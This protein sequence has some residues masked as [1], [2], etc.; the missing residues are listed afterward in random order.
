MSSFSPYLISWNTTKRCNLRCRHCYLDSDALTKKD[1]NELS[2]EEGKRL[3]D[4]IAIVNPATMLILTGGEPLVRED[5]F[6][7]SA[8]ASKKG[9]MVVFGTNATTL[10][11]KTAKEMIKAGV[12]GVGISVD[13]ASP[14][15]HDVFRGMEGAWDK[16]MDGI[17]SCK[18]HGIEFQ[19]Q[20]TVTTANYHEIRDII[21]LS[22][23]LGARVFNLF[24][25][26]CTGRGQDITDISAEQYEEALRLL[27]DIQGKYKN[28][29]VTARCAPHFKR[30]A[31]EKDPES[32][33]TKAAG[34]TGGGCLAAFH[35]CRITPEGDVTPCP[36]I[37]TSVGNVKKENF[38]D[39]WNK[40]D[41]FQNMRRPKLTGRCGDCEYEYICGGCRARAYAAKND[42]MAEDP[43]CKYEPGKIGYKIKPIIPPHPPLAKGGRGDLDTEEIGWSTEAE[44][45]LNKVPYFLK[46]MVKKAVEKH[47]IEKGLKEVTVSLMEEVRKKSGRPSFTK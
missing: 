38:A 28:M 39:I 40:A 1:P 47:A 22:H 24:F 4:Q 25:M 29:M 45:R 19:I 8:H 11:D 41:F 27:L 36:Y 44:E 3:I 26:V 16:A 10:D 32:P 31:Y 17:E 13:S 46:G 18:R 23:K 7:L 35:Y 42:I 14:K 15:Y 21:E 6:D 37:P 43:W 34:Y 5:I 30:L 2:L 33:I 20:T 12:A 9:L